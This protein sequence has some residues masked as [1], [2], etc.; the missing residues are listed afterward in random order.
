VQV[1]QEGQTIK[2]QQYGMGVVTASDPERTAIE[3]EDHGAKLFVT[4]MMSAELI[5]E[6]PANPVK[7]KRRRKVSAAA[8]AAKEAKKVAAAA[9]AR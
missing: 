4:G 6:A 9:A 5:G 8:K 2:H 3:F 7:P 1:M